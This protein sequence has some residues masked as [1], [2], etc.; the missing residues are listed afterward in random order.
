M[1]ARWVA[2]FA[3]LVAALLSLA[4]PAAVRAAEPA[5]IMVMLRLPPPHFRAGADYAANY[6]DDAARGSRRRIA[7]RLA[8]DHRLTLLTNWPV[9][10]LGV[11]CFIMAVPDGRS[12]DEA[13]DELAR[14]PDVSWS[15]PVALYAAQSEAAGHDDALFPAQPAAQLWRLADVHARVVG[16]GVSV[17]VIDSAVDAR[18]PDLAGQVA[19]SRNFVEGAAIPA[20]THGTAVAGIIAAHADNQVGIA[21]VAPGARIVALRACRQQEGRTSCDSLA[22]AKAIEFSIDRRLPII[23]MSLSGPPSRLLAG[24]LRIGL[25][26]GAVVV[27]AVDPTLPA[28]GFPA[29]L[30][31]VVAVSDRPESDLPRGVYVAPG[32]DIPAPQPGGRWSLVSGSSFSAAHM[33][34]LFALLRDDRAATLRLASDRPGGGA[35][36]ICRTF[37]INGCGAIRLAR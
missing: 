3:A 5:R 17:A 10:R 19:L 35:V 15:E 7:S 28:G 4:A 31:G 34:G 30:P 20:E 22:L 14:D 13:A 2:L 12:V 37:G 33:S 18:H 9:P 6:G 29:S 26:Q 16:R 11:D 25:A 24:L 21:G 1:T 32:R 23:N 8:R 36:D 27:A